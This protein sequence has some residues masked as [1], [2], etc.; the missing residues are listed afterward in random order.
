M[1]KLFLGLIIVIV[2]EE[3]CVTFWQ[4][5]PGRIEKWILRNA[6]D[7]EQ[8]PYLPKVLHFIYNI[9]EK[10]VMAHVNDTQS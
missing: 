1:P 7:D 6:F 2:L 4:I 9:T 3:L 10:N 8:T 5:K